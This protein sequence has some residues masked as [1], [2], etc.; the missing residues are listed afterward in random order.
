MKKEKEKKEEETLSITLSAQQIELTLHQTRLL[1]RL[2]DGK[3]PDYQQII[4]KGDATSVLFTTQ[5]LTSSVKR[6]HYFAKE[7]NNNP[8]FTIST[9]EAHIATPQTQLGKDE[10]T[11][12]AEATGPETKIALSSSYLLDFV[13]HITEE[14]LEMRVTDGMHPA[15]FR[16]PNNKHFLHLI[17]PLRMQ[18]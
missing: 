15:V 13:S 8:T 4:P 2:I 16:L 12:S 3:F 6:M 9:K 1:S 11:I 17:M 18:G 10:S 14:V 5:E 7:V